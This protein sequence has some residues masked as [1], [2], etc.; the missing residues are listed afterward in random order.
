MIKHHSALLRVYDN[1]PFL[2]PITIF[3]FILV[4]YISSV[5]DYFSSRNKKTKPDRFLELAK[6]D[7]ETGFSKPVP[8]EILKKHGLGFGNGGD[9]CRDD[10]SLGKKYNIERIKKAEELLL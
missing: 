9:W 8:I 10:S 5:Y 3:S 4:V 6:P 7:K 1:N 2:S